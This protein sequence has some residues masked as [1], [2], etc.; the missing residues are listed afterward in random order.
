MEKEIAGQEID[1]ELDISIDDLF[2]DEEDS[3]TSENSQTSSSDDSKNEEESMNLTKNMS[4]RIN[5]VRRK[6][7]LEV[8]DRVAKQ[9][10]YESY[11]DMMK[12]TERKIVEDQGYDPD[13]ISAL[14]E[15]LIEKRLALDPRF[16]KLE[17][18]EA[19]E[20]S[21]YLSKQLAEI[22]KVSEV[23]YKSVNDLPQ[24]TINLF[25]KGVDLKQAFYATQGEG[26][27]NRAASRANNGSLNHMAPL[28]NGNGVKTRGLTAEEKDMYRMIIPG[29]TEEELS[30]KTIEID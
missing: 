23:K 30:K 10:G 13:E 17:E 11:E 18:I 20:K 28:P 24:E 15:P 5:D 27:F 9:A 12:A 25:A 16:K 21:D 29:I 2:N 6:T 26:L 22:N 3:Q 8:Q 1:D 4:K 14:L 7:E 19:R